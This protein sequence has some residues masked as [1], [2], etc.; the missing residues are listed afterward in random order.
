[1]LIICLVIA[2]DF[3]LNNLPLYFNSS[4]NV[5]EKKCGYFRPVSDQL[6]EDDE[7]F[8]FS[9]RA[10]NSQDTFNNNDITIHVTII[11]DDGM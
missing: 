1:M 8:Y 6:V 9:A 11:D 3:T 5:G 2:A 4:S 10:M 7:S